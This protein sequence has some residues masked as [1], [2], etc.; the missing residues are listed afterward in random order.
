MVG[1]AAIQLLIGVIEQVFENGG[2]VV[3]AGLIK[4][5]DALGKAEAGFQRVVLKQ[6]E[7][8]ADEDVE[9]GGVGGIGE[10]PIGVQGGRQMA[11]GGGMGG[12]GESILARVGRRAGP[13]WEA[14]P[15]M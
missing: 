9:G 2:G 3:D 4:A 7:V 13:G 6:M 12:A 14:R 8:A 15:S 5:G 10:G 1:P 11:A